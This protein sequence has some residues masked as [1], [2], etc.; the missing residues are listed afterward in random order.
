MADPRSTRPSCRVTF[1]SPYWASASRGRSAGGRDRCPEPRARPDHPEAQGSGSRPGAHEQLFA[2]CRRPFGVAAREPASRPQAQRADKNAYV[3]RRAAPPSVALKDRG[4]TP[5]ALSGPR[6]KRIIAPEGADGERSEPE[7]AG[8]EDL[9]GPSA[10]LQ[11][12]CWAPTPTQRTPLGLPT[13]HRGCMMGGAAHR[14]SSMRRWQIRGA[15][16]R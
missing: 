8:G 1:T 12:G 10:P 6:G 3:C 16:G 13:E 2:V 4:P 11:R 14:S 15:G 9:A 7:A 5:P